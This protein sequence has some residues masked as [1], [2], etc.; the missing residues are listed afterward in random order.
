MIHSD[1]IILTIFSFID[2][3]TLCTSCSFV[4]KHFYA[5]SCFPSIWK[6]NCLTKAVFDNENAIENWKQ[7]Y[8]D[9]IL[10]RFIF[11][12]ANI[13]IDNCHTVSTISKLRTKGLPQ[14][15]A[16][17]KKVLFPG[18]IY[19]IKFRIT[20]T[21][22]LD[23]SIYDP[24]SCW[25]L[26]I[27]LIP[28]ERKNHKIFE[29]RSAAFLVGSLPDSIGFLPELE[30]FMT[31]SNTQP[32]VNRWDSYSANDEILLTV[33]LINGSCSCYWNG[34]IME[35]EGLTEVSMKVEIPI[36]KY[37]PAIS[38]SENQQVMIYPEHV[39]QF[40]DLNGNDCVNEVDDNETSNE[41]NTQFF[42]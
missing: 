23:T 10:Y 12:P 41:K 15:H 3:I 6:M 36:K 27:G 35:E 24:S 1:D 25:R 22:F 26:T 17:V 42:F 40:K 8:I 28:E 31:S 5:L 7:M 30:S 13:C 29:D 4:N 11:T 39:L 18:H 14:Y 38:L 21:E 33:D 2:P 37:V 19:T 9:L 16:R 32:E 20:E 34:Q